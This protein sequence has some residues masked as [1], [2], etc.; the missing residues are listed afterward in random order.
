MAIDIDWNTVLDRLLASDEVWIKKLSTND[1]SWADG[2]GNSHQAGF[3]VPR[4]IRE[5]SFFPDLRGLNPAKPH[6]FE[7]AI[8]TEWPGIGASRISRLVHYS[9]KGH[10]AHFTGVPPTSP[11]I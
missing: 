5:T 3:Y 7:A 9:N 4:A 6:I 11:Q 2:R 10:E 8:P 1:R